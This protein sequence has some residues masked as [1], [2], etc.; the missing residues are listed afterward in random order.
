MRRVV[1]L[2]LALVST[3]ASKAG[4]AYPNA[5]ARFG[6]DTYASASNFLVCILALTRPH[7]LIDAAQPGPKCRGSRPG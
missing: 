7:A 1:Q 2:S 5:L 4:D 6:H 3:Y